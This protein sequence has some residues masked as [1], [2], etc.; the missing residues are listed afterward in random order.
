MSFK[1]FAVRDFDTLVAFGS[2]ALC[3]IEP[4]F[5]TGA[6]QPLSI[7]II[8]S[9]GTGKSH[10]VNRFL[11]HLA[12]NRKRIFPGNPAYVSM[13][14]GGIQITAID[15]V[16]EKTTG[17]RPPASRVSSNLTIIE[18]PDETD[19]QMSG[20]V[21]QILTRSDQSHPLIG[22]IFSLVDRF[23]SVSGDAPPV[24]SLLRIQVKS[25]LQRSAGLGAFLQNKALPETVLRLSL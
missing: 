25:P 20:L 24:P 16:S 23:Q 2:E 3:S 11:G 6:S 19:L 21:M 22:T 10:I 9:A 5:Y 1:D 12:E 4:E 13:D 8:G 15:R 17:Q 14:I 18:H 7:A